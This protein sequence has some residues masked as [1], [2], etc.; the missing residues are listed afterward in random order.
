VGE[1]IPM[2]LPAGLSEWGRLRE[3][4][5]RMTA[6]L[7]AVGTNF[8]S[9][10]AQEEAERLAYVA[11]LGT[12]RSYFAALKA[13]EAN[14][15]ASLL[16][17][18]R[19]LASQFAAR[20]ALLHQG[21]P[22]F[23]VGPWALY[24][25]LLLLLGPMILAGVL[26]NLPPVL[27]GWLAGRKLADGLNVVALWRILVGLP[28]LVIWFGAVTILLAVFAAWWWLLGYLLLTLAALKLFY[29]A[30][31]LAVAAWNGLA[32][33]A[34]AGRAHELHQLVLQTLPSP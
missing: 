19:G 26:V 18:W 11:T 17:R 24:A 4:K 15:P 3:M 14:M 10:T 9:A 22:L 25:L 34:L 29:R 13:L 1:P 5:R 31:K 23:P 30:R 20:R 6:A 16:A 12:P 33:R 28:L 32:H 7:E 8:A 2:E 21:V 27:G